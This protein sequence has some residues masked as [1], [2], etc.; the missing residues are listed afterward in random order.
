MSSLTSRTI[1]PLSTITPSPER[2]HRQRQREPQHDRPHER[3]E[4]A[5]HGGGAERR[6]ELVD[7]HAAR[8]SRSS[9]PSVAAVSSQIDED[10]PDRRAVPLG[11]RRRVLA[12][13]ASPRARPA[14]LIA[15]LGP[16]GGRRSR[17]ARPAP[18]RAPRRRAHA[19]AASSA[20]SSRAA[21]RVGGAGAG[22]GTH[23]RAPV[24]RHRDPR[25]DQRGALAA[26][27][28]SRWPGPTVGPHPATGSSASVDRAG[29]LAHLGEQVGVAGEVAGLRARGHEADG[30]PR[31]VAMPASPCG[32]AGVAA[33][34]TPP[35]AVRARGRAPACCCMPCAA[36]QPP[37]PGRGDHERAARPDA[38]A[39]ARRRGRRAGGRSARR[40]SPR[41]VAGDRRS[42]AHER[43]DRA[44]A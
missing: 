3:V 28:G 44:R 12:A 31:A 10:P 23:E 6:P 13:P 40:R 30:A 35:T 16:R 24:D 25:G 26:R 5:D 42:D 21:R 19:R 37:A 4:Q 14:R 27:S 9:A 39:S 7:L 34:P 17:C 18:A 1:A 36:S 33:T 8:A 20:K 43:A 32:C 22:E 11:A 29:Q 38:A 2:Q 15:A 41:G